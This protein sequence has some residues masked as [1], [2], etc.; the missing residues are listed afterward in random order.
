MLKLAI[1]DL[2]KKSICEGHL[3]ISTSEGKR[4]YVMKPGMYLDASFL[5]KHAKFNTI[6]DY[7]EVVNQDVVEQFSKLFKELKYLHFEKDLRLKC[8]EIIKMFIDVYSREEHL[9]SFVLACHKEFNS[10]SEETL[11]KIHETDLHLF[12]KS[13][14]SASLSILIGM[15]NDFY[16]YPMLK[17]FY[18]LTAALD[19]GLCEKGYS[20]FVA[21]AC[22][23]EN[24][25]PGSGKDWLV[26]E[27]ASEGEIEVFLNHPTKSYN[28]FKNAKNLIYFEELSEIALYQHELAKGNGFPRGIH[29]A[30]VSTWEAV[31]VLADSLF[32][33]KDQYDFEKDFLNYIL[34]F[35]NQKLNVLPVSKVFKRMTKGLMFYQNELGAQV[36]G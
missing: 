2:A 20:Y 13:I 1:K 19:I 30:Q 21:E 27:R 34:N 33:I 29:K 23:K 18:N 4:F 17:D 36:N 32:E 10:H 8:A 5:K 6:F 9:L 31:V 26:S 25:L 28:F 11:A 24:Q 3:Y 14:Y 35:T 16:H 22:N 7:D 12:R 15:T